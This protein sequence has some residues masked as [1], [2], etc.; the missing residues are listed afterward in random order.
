MVY[1]ALSVYRHMYTY[2]DISG[3]IP[4]DVRGPLV[5]GYNRDTDTVLSGNKLGSYL[6]LRAF[7]SGEASRTTQD[8]EPS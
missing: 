7:V 4:Y 5:E 6:T 1:F 2:T 8:R 3:G